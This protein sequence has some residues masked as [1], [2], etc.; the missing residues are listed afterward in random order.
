MKAKCIRRR[1]MT[2]FEVIVVL[3]IIMT[4][5]TVVGRNMKGGFEAGKC[6]KSEQ[7]SKTVYEILTMEMAQG[8]SLAEVL[9]SPEKVLEK[10]SLTNHPKQM[11]KDGWGDCY[12]IVSTD[13]GDIKVV[14]Q[15]FLNIKRK[16]LSEE[17]LADQYPWMVHGQVDSK[18]ST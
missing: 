7:G 18:I 11:L 10:S 8:S 9:E 16:T 2:L 13:D 5:G 4:I 1:A 17:Q 14:S 12:E 15:K 6:F 3:F